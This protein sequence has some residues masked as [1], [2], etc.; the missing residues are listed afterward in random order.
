MIQNNVFHRKTKGRILVVE[1]EPLIAGMI[2][3]VLNEQGF[4][5]VGSATTLPS[6]EVFV[7]NVS[8]DAVL[9]DLR[10]KDGYAY[11]LCEMLDEL[12]IPFAFVTAFPQEFIV[13]EWRERPYCG[14]PFS[15]EDIV[16]TV[17]SL[18]R[19]RQNVVHL[20]LT[21]VQHKQ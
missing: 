11:S 10:M 8:V 4:S 5:C 16:D 18:M 21:A 15:E 9:L 7:R 6:A 19:E 20:L 13:E 3:N 12:N 1:D 2:E 14:K 17:Y